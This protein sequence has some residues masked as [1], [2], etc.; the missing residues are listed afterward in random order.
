MS[1]LPAPCG[2]S[3]RIDV[4]LAVGGPE[5]D[6]HVMGGVTHAGDLE[7][8]N[9]VLRFDAKAGWVPV[10][11]A[12]PEE[13]DYCW[14]VAVDPAGKP[15]LGCDLPPKAGSL[16]ARG[17]VYALSNDAWERVGEPFAEGGVA[18]VAVDPSGVLWAAGGGA[19]GFALAGSFAAGFWPAGRGASFGCSAAST[20]GGSF[21]RRRK[22]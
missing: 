17:V 14:S 21:F 11:P 2:P 4:A 13:A 22:K 12:V 20:W 6:V 10:G 16:D 18:A 5:C 9:R 8:D 7:V 15:Y 19:E 3:C 1:S